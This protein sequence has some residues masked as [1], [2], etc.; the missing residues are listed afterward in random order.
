VGWGGIID[1][2]DVRGGQI[3]HLQRRHPLGTSRKGPPIGL[4]HGRSLKLPGVPPRKTHS[5]PSP[6]CVALVSMGMSA[7][8]V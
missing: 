8:A 5:V 7:Q 6:T 3:P 2:V 4:P 1:R